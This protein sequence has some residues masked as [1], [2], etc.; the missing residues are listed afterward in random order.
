[1]QADK[2][3]TLMCSFAQVRGCRMW[4]RVAGTHAESS[5]TPWLHT[6]IATGTKNGYE[7]LGYKLYS[8]QVWNL[9][10]Y[11]PQPLQV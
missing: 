4:R 11:P 8:L 7:P 2:L 10:E 1:M 5:D 9:F 6:P 3:S